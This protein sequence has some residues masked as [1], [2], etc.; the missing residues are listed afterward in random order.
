MPSAAS[1]DTDPGVGLSRHGEAVPMPQGGA[2]MPAS[3]GSAQMP[4]EIREISTRAGAP[5]DRAPD[6][7]AGDMP[8]RCRR[9]DIRSQPE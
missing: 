1:S 7:G 9:G 8:G 4:G 6:S 2:P 3:P 5:D